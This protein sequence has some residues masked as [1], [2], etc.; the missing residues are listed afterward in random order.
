M[1]AV[2]SFALP[3]VC[4]LLEGRGVFLVPCAP[5]R[6]CAFPWHCEAG[7]VNKL[8]PQSP[9]QGWGPGQCHSAP[10]EL[11]G[12]DSKVWST[13]KDMFQPSL[14]LALSWGAG[15][16][17]SHSDGA[18][19]AGREVSFIWLMFSNAWGGIHSISWRLHLLI[20]GLFLQ[21]GHLLLCQI[22][23][24]QSPITGGWVAH[25]D[26][27][28][29]GTVPTLVRTQHWTH[30]IPAFTAV[31]VPHYCS[32]SS[33]LHRAALEMSCT[34][35]TDSE[36]PAALLLLVTMSSLITWS[37]PSFLEA[38][39]GLWAPHDL[40]TQPWTQW[41]PSNSVRLHFNYNSNNNVNL[42]PWCLWIG[43]AEK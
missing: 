21:E 39:S 36:P 19:W 33:H 10:G 26:F 40:Y 42:S 20:S 7:A 43:F 27:P 29:L 32:F 17:N 34:V 41:H 4:W 13:P 35:H 15:T 23:T 16:E 28:P 30:L 9:L 31:S 5:G 24:S 22:L 25:M 8:L 14:D 3:V 2:L 6:G 18:Q 37:F 11:Q 12:E 1:F 38:H